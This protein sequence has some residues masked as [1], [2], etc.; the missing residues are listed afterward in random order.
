MTPDL[1]TFL[2]L[3]SQGTVIPVWKAI[4]A[5]MLTPVSAYLHLV[6]KAKHAFLLESA[7]DG[8]HVALYTFLGV[9]PHLIVRSRGEDV[10]ISEG[11][12]ITHRKGHVLD[13]LREIVKGYRSVS[14]P[15][16]PPFT[17]GAVGY[18]GY[19][20]VGQFE[21]AP[22]PKKAGAT[23]LPDSV[24][25]FFQNVLVFDHVKHQIFIVSSVFNPPGRSKM[26][27][28]AA[29]RRAERE[30]LRIEKLLGRTIPQ[31]HARLK[32]LVKS[33]ANMSQPVFERSVRRALEYIAAGDVFQVVLSLRLET[34]LPVDPFLVYRAL[35]MVNPS[36]YMFF[37]QM[38]KDRVLGSSPEML[39][40]VTGRDVEYRPIA[41]TRRRTGNEQMDA[42]LA[43][44]LKS[45]EKEQAEHIM[46]VDLGRNDVGR[47]SEYG[48]VRIPESKLMFVERYSHVMHLVSSIRGTLRAGLD[49]FDALASCF[50][51]GTLS[52]APKVRAMEI[53]HELEPTRRGVY[54]GSVMYLD[55][56]GNLNSC[57]AIRTLAVHGKRAYLQ[58]GAGIVA[59]SDPTKEYEESMNKSRAVLHAIEEATT[60]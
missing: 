37:L 40:K 31:P 30:I 58:V 18:L 60:L 47:I 56:S 11:R 8:E 48:S 59:D 24:F 29:Y 55:Y 41:G 34:A 39:V 16:M 10:E 35:R 12:K 14:V 2:N 28:T 27:L 45:D 22:E 36:P 43:A 51:A 49:I 57:I 4:A 9:D 23:G 53:I 7:E 54:G 19:D 50:P 15:G 25:M 33:K 20:T 21:R 44:E 26:Q 32:R 52:G 3:A 46:L 17:A 38:D 6:G 5:D 13:T 42:A 1:K